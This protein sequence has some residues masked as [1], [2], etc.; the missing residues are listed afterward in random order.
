MN[1]SF[2]SLIYEKDT[3]LKIFAVEMKQREFSECIA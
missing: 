2:C 3:T 1:V